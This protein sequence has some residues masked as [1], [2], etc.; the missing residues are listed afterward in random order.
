IIIMLKIGLTGGIGSGKT[1]VAKIFETLGVPVYY[2]DD[3]AK[4]LMQEDNVLKQSIIN[5]FGKDSY[6]TDGKL[7]RS[8]LSSTVFSNPHQ[9]E[10]LNAIVHPATIQHAEQ[11]M[12]QQQAPYVIK[13]AALIFESGSQST[14][15]YVIG[16]YAPQA[17]RIQR[18]I[19]RDNI[20]KDKVLQRMQN[21]I[22]ENIKMRL[23]DRVIQ[24]DDQHSLM[25]QVLM[26]HETL[27]PFLCMK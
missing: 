23:C 12:Q 14:L 10:R 21:Q 5:I 26:V 2:A 3:V 18:T 7:N 20:D 25:Q 9:L 15:D 17:L 6:T 22:D 27:M 11:W 13:E 8:Y 24:N 19:K 1:T 16:V 4:Q